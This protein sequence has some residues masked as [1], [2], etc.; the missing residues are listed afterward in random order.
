MNVHALVSHE[1]RTNCTRRRDQGAAQKRT[2]HDA[3]VAPAS[4]PPASHHHV[5]IEDDNDEGGYEFDDNA[6]EPDLALPPPQL[7]PPGVP[8][9]VAVERQRR[10]LTDAELEEIRSKS[11]N[12]D[13]QYGVLGEF[14][15]VCNTVCHGLAAVHSA[16]HA[17]LVFVQTGQSA[18]R[19]VI[20]H[21]LMQYKG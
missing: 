15:L 16:C 12:L 7:P 10:A 4:P 21:F 9:A 19:Q 13:A 18:A 8:A 1:S 6:P 5:I 17:A 14:H 3:A 11:D 2:W 20:C